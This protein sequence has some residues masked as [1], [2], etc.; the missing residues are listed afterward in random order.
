MSK[1]YVYDPKYS[2]LLLGIKK[3]IILISL[4]WWVDGDSNPEPM[5]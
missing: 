2:L 3:D 4:V 5:A 1:P